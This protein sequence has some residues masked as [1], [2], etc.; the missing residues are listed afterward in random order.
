MSISNLSQRA[1]ATLLG[2]AAI[3][4]F[5]WQVG[6]QME[7]AA[8]KQR[9]SV[10]RD[11]GVVRVRLEHALAARLEIVN[12][13]AA[14]VAVDPAVTPDRFRR[15]SEAA[16]ARLPAIRSVQLARDAVV[17]HIFPLEGNAAAL[18]HDLRADPA[19]SAMTEETIRG[20]RFVL[21]GPVELRQGG[22]AV[23]G[24]L[25]IFLGSDRELFWGLATV[26]IDLQ[27]L[28][29]EAGVDDAESELEIAIRGRDGSGADGA[30]FYGR[31]EILDGS[32]VAAEVRF[33]GGSWQ[34]LARPARGWSMLGPDGTL[35][36]ALGVEA[37]LLMALL[38]ALFALVRRAEAE[39]GRLRQAVREAR[40][41]LQTALD[42]I[43]EG[44]AYYNADD[45]LVVFNKRYREF[46]QASAPAIFEGALF[47]DVIRY[48]AEHGQYQGAI[49]D[50]DAFVAERVRRH[51]EPQGTILQQHQNGRWIQISERRTPDGGIAGIRTDVTALKRIEDELRVANETLEER[52]RE[53]VADLDR[54]AE[55]LRAE[56]ESN[57]LLAAVVNSIPSGVTIS[58]ARLPD[59]PLIYCNPGFTSITGYNL[60]DIR[61]K[62]CR[63]LTGPDSDPDARRKLRDG[64]ADGLRVHVEIRNY[65]KDGEEF[66]NDLS[67]FPVRAADGSITHFVGVQ[68]DASER[69]EAREE[70]ER[71][72]R[73]V[74]ESGKFEA[75]GTLA[76]GI[77][78]EINTPVQYLSD[79]LGFLK[80]SFQE[81]SSVLDACRQVA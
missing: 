46:Y 81:L 14:L 21:S 19:R 50:V 77:A 51:R 68:V 36:Q 24:R 80:S 17:S 37:G 70:H 6:V 52:V 60:D 8:S 9:V 41:Q 73:R 78:H 57:A 67:V 1:L 4:F 39:P 48:G 62:N 5:S 2:V 53:R 31:Q 35:L 76:G 44:F 7:L 49:G 13:L 69:R 56:V 45:R 20:R 32:P 61:G 64:I 54:I 26:V 40:K 18:G 22:T 25:P 23:I 47:A 27:P 79:N 59:N 3:A 58:D 16:T 34:L 29:S 11:L 33:E 28:L 38:A 42:T 71:M 66:W 72:Q 30:L 12:G 63:F 10:S 15:F 75:L 55:E 74:M 65:R 43:T